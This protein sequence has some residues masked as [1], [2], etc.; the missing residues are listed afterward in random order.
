M[1][2]I[3]ANVGV[4]IAIA[5]LGLGLVTVLRSN[6]QSNA[7]NEKTSQTTNTRLSGIQADLAKGS[8]LLD[9]RTTEEFKARHAKAATLWPLQDIQAGKPPETEKTRKIY[10]YCRSGNRSAQAKQLLEQAGFTSV[11]DL[12]GLAAVERIG[13]EMVGNGK[14]L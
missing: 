9:V 1:K 5:L 10:V 14:T 13:L 4:A 11:I 8:L 12:G 3:I 6:T 2:K 7:G